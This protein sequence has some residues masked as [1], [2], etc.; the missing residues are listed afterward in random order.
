MEGRH[1]AVVWGF[2]VS[3]RLFELTAKT[4]YYFAAKT[5]ELKVDVC[6]HHKTEVYCAENDNN[7][8]LPKSKQL[9]FA[10]VG[11]LSILKY[12]N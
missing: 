5:T 1:R 3:P 2:P 9:S 7:K 6:S 4:S 12:H 8:C 10:L 11:H